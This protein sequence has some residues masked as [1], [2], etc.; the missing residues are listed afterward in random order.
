MVVI[1][2]SINDLSIS[3]QNLTDILQQVI[4]DLGVGSSELLIRIV[5]IA[6][7]QNLNKTYRNQD[8]PT[9]VLSF[10][11]D[12]PKE[13]NEAILGDVVICSAVVKAE[14]RVQDKT[15]EHHLTHIAVHGALH[16]LG[17]DHIE[18]SEAE[19]MEALEIKILHGLKI[20]NPYQ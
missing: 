12:L 8:K 15:F 3:A 9:N 10:S 1:Q 19:A 7:I 18:E 14:A 17:Y 13:I 16:L 20:C 4:A 11:S 6:E 2:N 5:D